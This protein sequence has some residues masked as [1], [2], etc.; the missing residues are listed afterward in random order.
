M[1]YSLLAA[2]AVCAGVCRP[3]RAAE[4]TLRRESFDTEPRWEGH[5]NRIARRLSPETVRQDFGY[6]PGSCRAGGDPGEMG[7]RI[8]SAVEAAYYARRIPIRTFRDRLGA[9]GKLL[10]ERGSSKRVHCV[11]RTETT[12]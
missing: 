3:T 11:V 4:P 5:N 12:S 1:A 7:G 6:S 10:V 2:A 9:S 8:D